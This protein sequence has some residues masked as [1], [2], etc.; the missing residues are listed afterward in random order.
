MR[1]L[2]TLDWA[3]LTVASLGGLALLWG[4]GLGFAVKLQECAA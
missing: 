2:D 1:R 3:V 4:V